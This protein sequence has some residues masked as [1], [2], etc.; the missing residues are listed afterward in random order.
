[1]LLVVF[2]ASVAVQH[3]SVFLVAGHRQRGF[4]ATLRACC[5]AAGAPMAVS[6]IPLAGLLTGFYSLYLLTTGLKRVHGMRDARAVAAVMIPMV[7]FVALMAGGIFLAYEAVRGAA[8]EPISYY[9]PAPEAQEDLPPGVIGAAALMD[10]NEDQAR[11]RRLRSDAYD[12][13]SP[14]SDGGDTVVSVATADPEG[15]PRGVKGS[16]VD[17]SGDAVTIDA[18]NPEKESRGGIDNI[19]YYTDTTKST[20]PPDFYD[21]PITQELFF[22]S[23]RWSATSPTPSISSRSARNHAISP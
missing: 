16:A 1:M 20:S 11:V 7:H 14:V 17:E 4:R 23:F 3:A 5:Y 15:H 8:R 21:D 22:Q 13:W 19:L 2:C 12:T 10:G 6:W 18:E 9:F